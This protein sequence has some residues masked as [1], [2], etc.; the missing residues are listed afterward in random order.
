MSA[1]GPFAD[2]GRKGRNVRFQGCDGTNFR[3]Y[4]ANRDRVP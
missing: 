4:R 3:G 2:L 1:V